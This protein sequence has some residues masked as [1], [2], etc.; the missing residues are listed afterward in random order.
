MNATALHPL[1]SDFNVA[2]RILLSG[3]SHQAW[4]NV[5]KQGL[6]DCYNDAAKEVDDKWAAAFDKAN[7]VSNFY[8]TLLD[9]PNGQITLGASTHEL[10]LRFLSDLNWF[11]QTP[12]RPLRIVTTDGEFHSMRRQLDRLKSLHVDIEVVP[13][14]PADTLAERLIEKINRQTDAVMLSA[15]FFAT[16]EIFREVGDVAKAAKSLDIPCLIDV[17]HA[18]NVIPFSIYDWQ[19]ESAFIVGGGYKYCQA[20]EGNCF[21]RIP[22]DYNGSPIITG[23]FA[24]FDALDQAPGEVGYG[25]GQSAF[26][27][28]TYDPASHYRAAAVFDF[29]EQQGLDA[30]TLSVINRRQISMLWQGIEAMGL[31][32]S[33][34][35]LPSHCIERNAGFLSLTTKNANEWVKQLAV[36]NIKTDSRG[37]QLRL[38]PA[39]YVS[40]EQLAHALNVIEHIAQSV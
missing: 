11:K 13:T 35:H 17:Y 14:A 3:H 33:V 24:E 23:W 28:S 30:N 6:I 34:L 40:D 39:P 26:A 20:G 21:M 32:T 8:R 12:S 1:Y 29:F 38:G 36:H 27:G 4:P 37:D 25:Q 5:A 2:N 19:I 22:A 7:I 10:I 9:E 18:L 15:V 31:P 16:S